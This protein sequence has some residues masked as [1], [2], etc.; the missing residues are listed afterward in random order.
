MSDVNL[1]RSGPPETV[2]DAEPADVF[3]SEPDE[4]WR[5]VLRRQSG[6]LAWLATA[7]DDLS[8]N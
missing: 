2:L 4:L 5:A 7:P 3:A 8:A 1:S 6:R